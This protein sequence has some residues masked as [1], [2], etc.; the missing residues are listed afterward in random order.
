[1]KSLI[2]I[3]TGTMESGMIAI[4]TISFVLLLSV[5]IVLEIVGRGTPIEWAESNATLNRLQRMHVL[6]ESLNSNQRAGVLASISACHDGYTITTVQH[7]QA[8]RNTRTAALETRIAEHLEINVN[9]VSVGYNNLGRNDFS[10]RTCSEAEIDLPMIAIVISIQ[11]QSGE[12]FNSEVHPH[13]WHLQDLL[14]RILRYIAAFILVGFIAI[15]LIRRLSKPL[16]N[17]T[18]AAQQFADGLKVSPV[19]ESGPPDLKH[20]IASFNAM[21]RQVAADVKQRTDTL[22]AI[23]HDLRTPLTAL[24]IKTE[25]VEDDETR[26]SLNVSINKMEKIIAS[27][28]EFLRGEARSEPMRHIDLSAMLASECSDFEDAG[29]QAEFIGA[30]GLHWTCRPEALAS[31]VRNLIENANKY[32]GGAKVDLLI[33]D[34]GLDISVFDTGP[35][36]PHDKFE[37][38]LEPFHRLSEARESDQGGFGLGLTIA[39]AIAEGH[40]G[41]LIL[42]SNN[43]TGLIVMIRLPSTSI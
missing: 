23:S 18:R 8:N 38:A 17:L 35:G 14:G 20:A 4:L 43:P 31:A 16:K 11:L 15:F 6:L 33:S 39:K 29:Q 32:G 34:A 37:S 3:I 27:A 26:E 41:E 9:E 24:R 21:Q 36:I 7:P 22:A 30:K 42:R 10:Y 12:W 1:M 5:L 13:E 25:F 28:L 2:R 40:D 19:S